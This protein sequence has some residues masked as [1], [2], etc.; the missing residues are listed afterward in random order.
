MSSI[1]ALIVLVVAIWLAIKVVGFL[2]K[3]GLILLA[4]AAAYWVVAHV[5]GM[6][7]PF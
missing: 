3:I 5:A 2:F 4:L 7:L 1:V 6:P